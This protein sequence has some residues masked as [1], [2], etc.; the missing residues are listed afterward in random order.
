V[1]TINKKLLQKKN[2]PL[3]VA[4]GV[5][6]SLVLFFVYNYLSNKNTSSAPDPAPDSIN[7]TSYA[8]PTD[9]EINAGKQIKDN[10]FNNSE[11]DVNNTDNS[12]KNVAVIVSNASVY[13]ST[14]E[15]QAFIPDF[16]EN[17]VCTIRIN[18][19]DVNI[20]KEVNAYADATSTICTNPNI[21]V[22]ELSQGTWSVEVSYD[23]PKAMGRST[24][25]S[26]VVN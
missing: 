5:V 1:P 23:S 18:K 20:T 22:D 9:E 7:N 15:I 21:D 6:L 26:L 12:K 8:A 24:I 2:G 16:I 13:R 3:I 25:T 19:G 4:L 10:S 14:V 17:G 11:T